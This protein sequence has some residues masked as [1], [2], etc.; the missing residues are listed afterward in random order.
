MKPP[1]FRF[2]IAML[3]VAATTTWGGRAAQAVVIFNDFGPGDTYNTSIGYTI[4]VG[5][6]VNIDFDQGNTFTPLGG[7]FRLD[8][9]AVAVGLVIGSNALDVWLMTDA[10]GIPGTV[11]ESFSFSGMG[12]FGN[13]NPP[14]LAN[15]V[16]HPVLAAG[17]PYWLIASMP[18]P[19]SWAAWSFNSIGATGPRATRQDLGAWVDGND[20]MAAFRITGTAV[21]EPATLFLVGAGLGG[22]IRAERRR[23]GRR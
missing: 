21:P 17:T 4:S 9:V 11:I 3:V 18:G 1:R 15:S 19:D 12:P 5:Q 6:P 20:T 22:L 23:Y 13:L 16:L 10:G 7:T 14:L 2:F 8:T